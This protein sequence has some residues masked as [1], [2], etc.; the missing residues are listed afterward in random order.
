VRARRVHHASAPR[1][2][3]KI[4]IRDD[5][6]RALMVLCHL[7]SAVLQRTQYCHFLLKE[8][9]GSKVYVNDKVHNDPTG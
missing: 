2:T 3:F 9:D 4:G 5:A 6:R 1:A 8:T 7:E